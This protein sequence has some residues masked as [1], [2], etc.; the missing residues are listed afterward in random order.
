MQDR[1]RLLH[2]VI[3]GVPPVDRIRLSA[4]HASGERERLALRK[5]LCQK[6][7]ADAGPSADQFPGVGPSCL[8][9]PHGGHC[10]E[11]RLDRMAAISLQI[12][13]DD[14]APFGA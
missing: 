7:H 6:R 11:E 9:D 13:P 4:R 5:T 12:V 8:E 3:I 1:S 10:M 14:H 2:P